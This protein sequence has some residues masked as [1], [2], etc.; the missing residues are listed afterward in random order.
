MHFSPLM[1]QPF[2]GASKA[3]SKLQHAHPYPFWTKLIE[4]EMDLE[5]TKVI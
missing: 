1:F 5:E 3:C 2:P 4:D